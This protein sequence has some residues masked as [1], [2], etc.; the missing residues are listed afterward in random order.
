MVLVS[1]ALGQSD[2]SFEALHDEAMEAFESK[3]WELA[4]RRMAELLSLDGTDAILQMRYGATLLHDAR[5]RDE[6][7]QRLASLA[8]A[9]K[10]EGEGWYWWGRAWMLQGE[11]Q[12]AETALLRALQEAEKKSSWIEACSLALAQS[13]S[14]PMSFDVMQPLRKLDALAV[15]STSY[16]R[17][18]DWGREGVRIMLAPQELQSKLD[19]KNQVHSPVTF[20]RGESELFYHSVGS[21]GSQGLDIFAATLDEEGEFSKSSSLSKRVNSPWDDINPVWDPS[22]QCLTFASNRPGTVGG[23]DLFQTC[24]ED[25]IWSIPHSLG[26]MFNS[27]HDDLAFY[28]PHHGTSGWLVTGRQAAYGGIEVWEVDLDGESLI[29][30]NLNTQWAVS[31]EVIPGKLRL[32]DAESEEAIAEV[33]LGKAKGQ[34]NVVVGAGQVLRYSFETRNGETIEGTYAVPDAEVPSSVSQ[35][36]VMTMV[37]GSL[38]LDARPL[39]REAEPSPDLTWGWNLVLDEVSSINLEDLVP[40]SEE[41]VLDVA[42]DTVIPRRVV[43]FQTYPWWTEIQKEERAIAANVLSKHVTTTLLQLPN[44]RD[45]DELSDY[46]NALKRVKEAYEAEAISTVLAAAAKEII[47]EE[48]PWEEA[49]SLATSRASEHWAVGSLNVEDVARKARRAWARSGE[50]YDEGVLPKVKDKMR[51]VGDGE[52]IEKSW[53]SGH[54]EELAD[55]WKEL[56][57]LDAQTVKLLWALA[58]SPEATSSWDESW[59]QP[60]VWDADAIQTLLNKSESSNTITLDAIRTRLSILQSMELSAIWTEEDQIQSMREWKSIALLAASKRESHL[61]SQEGRHAEEEPRNPN[62]EDMLSDLNA[63]PSSRVEQVAALSDSNL[64]ETLNADWTSIWLQHQSDRSV[65]SEVSEERLAAMSQETNEWFS[66]LS[67]WVSERMK[68]GGVMRPSELIR[69]AARSVQITNGST[70]G[71]LTDSERPKPEIQTSSHEDVLRKSK[72][73]LL[74]ALLKRSDEIL[75]AREA[76][77]VLEA[78]WVATLWMCHPNWKHRSPEQIQACMP[79]WPREV[80]KHLSDMRVEWAKS[81]QNDRDPNSL[82]VSEE[83]LSVQLPND[84]LEVNQDE[85]W[86]HGENAEEVGVDTTS[87]M[88]FA[89]PGVVG[90]RGVHLGWFKQEP[91]LESLPA[92][93]ALEEQQGKNG[94]KRWVLVFPRKASSNLMQSIESWLMRQRILD[95]YEVFRDE[96]G[97]TTLI[98][99]MSIDLTEREATNAELQTDDAA[100]LSVDSSA[101]AYGEMAP[102]SSEGYS[103]SHQWGHEDLWANG[104]P[105]ALGNLRGT[106][107]AVQVG[108]FRGL[109]EKQWIEMAGERLIYEPFN[110]GLARW[111]AGIRQDKEST[112]SRL[113]ELQ[114]FDA[115]EDAFIVRLK[116]GEREVVRPGEEIS[117]DLFLALEDANQRTNEENVTEVVVDERL[118]DASP[119]GGSVEDLDGPSGQEQP[120]IEHTEAHASPALVSSNL[121][122]ASEANSWHVDIAKYYGTVPSQDVASLLI[123]AADWGVRSVQLFGQTTYFSRSLNDLNEAEQLL[124]SISSEGF[125]NATLVQE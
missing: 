66:E 45:F 24:R 94:L 87:Q 10:L 67:L 41:V 26:P 113:S 27:V 114:Q 72:A 8:D 55:R 116:D 59:F 34:W 88:A 124:R 62:S 18:V 47:L 28:P 15:S 90:S 68:R 53:R 103:E 109:P 121:V 97:W 98:P 3:Q 36:M 78:T 117:D 70:F 111:Y 23:F 30:V 43:Q 76:F 7:I 56:Q 51:L 16:H 92:G 79:N 5:M 91:Q 9:G 123:K 54:V 112:M 57:R 120:G 81:V 38:F 29:P 125:T 52:W 104:A 105:V 115:F 12:L 19:K 37:D 83:T 82:L 106:W 58:R 44:A 32:M 35:S 48:M 99:Q 73:E 33:E 20:W 42:V 49:L 95:S 101:I 11:S 31:G 102:N 108:A 74:E 4:H 40:L 6:G 14:L 110:D 85:P 77:Q 21:K 63:N 2:M 1:N 71:E 13:R 107:Y 80:Q 22:L 65:L 93:T 122:L 89:Q 64:I 100:T 69:D 50:L 119:S 39:A 96:N 17:Y 25:G 75:D 86:M 84:D 118:T 60:E 61:T 46:N